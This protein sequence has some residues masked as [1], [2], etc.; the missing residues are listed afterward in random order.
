MTM[1]PFAE[2]SLFNSVDNPLIPL[3]KDYDPLRIFIVQPQRIITQQDFL[4]DLS[5]LATQLPKG[6]YVFNV[7]EDRYYFLLAFC[8]ALLNQTVNLLPPTRRRHMLNTIAADYPQCYCLTDSDI[9]S[10]LPVVDLRLLKSARNT[11]LTAP[12]SIPAQQ[13]AAIAFTSGSTGIPA[14]NKKYWGTLAGTAQLLARR[15][16]AHL[17][18]P[19]LVATVPSQHMYGLEM[20]VMMALQGN[21]SIH[22][23][24]PFFPADI[25]KTLQLLPA[26]V[27][28]VSSPIHLRA[29]VNSG[30]A[31]PKLAGVVSATAPLDP[32]LALAAEQCFA[33]TLR[34]IY[35]CTEAGSMATR[36]STHTSVWQLLDGF[37]LT[38]SNRGY[39]ANAYHLAEQAPLQDQL[40][41]LGPNEF[42]L[43]GRNADMINVAGKRASLADLTLKLLRIDGVE[44]GVVF[45]VNPD[46]NDER[47]VA[48]V[49]SDLS[50]KAILQQLAGHIDAAFLPRPLRKV[51]ALPRNEIGK[52]TRAALQALWLK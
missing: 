26:P 17:D 52:L 35:G 29:M 30:L 46:R 39:A 33:T 47:P 2:A 37:A 1:S 36:R 9:Q 38:E 7:C 42:L 18:N 8:A 20:T 19:T 40:Q 51:A 21:C 34:E 27:I 10:D 48:L 25:S 22:S 23:A 32:A 12:P 11:Q 15:L 3:L 44:D 14:A 43:L 28:L 5:A 45:L 41:V 6:N 31:M 24:R 13:L 16:T 4:Q 50:E 49:V